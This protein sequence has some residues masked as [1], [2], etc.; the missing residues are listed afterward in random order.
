MRFRLKSKIQQIY[1]KSTE[2]LFEQQKKQKQKTTT[3][4]NKQTN[5]KKQKQKT[6]ET[7]K[8]RKWNNTHT[9]VP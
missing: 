2:Y 9:S 4:E 7:N 3:T 5:K 6:P 8:V 1:R